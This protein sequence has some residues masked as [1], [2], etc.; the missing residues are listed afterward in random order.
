MF[1]GWLS[2]QDEAN[3]HN[4]NSNTIAESF[5]ASASVVFSDVLYSS[6]SV[7]SHILL[8]LK[9]QADWCACCSDL[10]LIK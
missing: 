1:L 7:L 5:E 2:D 9:Q 6:R 10:S 3:S 4:C 8:A